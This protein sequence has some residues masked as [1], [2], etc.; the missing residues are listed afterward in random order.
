ML[1]YMFYDELSALE[2]NIFELCQQNLGKYKHNPRRYCNCEGRS[3]P[4]QSEADRLNFD[5]LN[6]KIALE[7][8]LSSFSAA[9]S[10][11]THPYKT[12]RSF[13][14]AYTFLYTIWFDYTFTAWILLSDLVS[15]SIRGR[16]QFEHSSTSCSKASVGSTKV[17]IRRPSQL[18]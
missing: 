10:H 7:V 11:E 8:F 5:L 12:G 17:I 4:N 16:A 14:R 13:A 18:A 1:S 3:E 15:K 9:L 6:A 2:T